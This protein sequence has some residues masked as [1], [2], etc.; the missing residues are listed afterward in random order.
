MNSGG[1]INCIKKYTVT[2]KHRASCN[3]DEST[4]L[5]YTQSLHPL[6]LPMTA[7]ALSQWQR[8]LSVC[9]SAVP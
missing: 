9:I 6:L 4:E 3:A 8:I 5:Y 1:N 7:V 2:S